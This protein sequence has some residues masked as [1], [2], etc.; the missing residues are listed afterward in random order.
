VPRYPEIEVKLTDEDGNALHLIG[1]VVEAL[2][3]NQVDREFVEK[4]KKEA[5]SGDYDNVL[6][7]CMAWV[8]VL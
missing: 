4:F 6:R 8:D 5:L 2:R 3:R 1:L 7:T